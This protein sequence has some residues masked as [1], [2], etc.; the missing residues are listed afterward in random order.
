MSCRSGSGRSR[1]SCGTQPT[2]PCPSCPSCCASTGAIHIADKHACMIASRVTSNHTS[3]FQTLA[4]TVLVFL[5]DLRG[6]PLFCKF[7]FKFRYLDGANVVSGIESLGGKIQIPQVF[8]SFEGIGLYLGGKRRHPV[9]PDQKS[10]ASHERGSKE[11]AP[12]R[13][14]P[15]FAS[16]SATDDCFIFP[17]HCKSPSDNVPLGST[18]KKGPDFSPRP[19]SC[20]LYGCSA[21]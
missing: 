8:A 16:Q 7:I 5:P 13:V 21:V 2:T 17:S 9:K 6:T 1:I 10:A 19:L 4:C 12:C 20:D 14:W 11:V 3:L 18:Q 15:G